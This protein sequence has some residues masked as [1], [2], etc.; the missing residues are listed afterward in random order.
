MVPG[1]NHHGTSFTCTI[2]E[3]DKEYDELSQIIQNYCQPSDYLPG[4]GEDTEIYFFQQKHGE[5]RWTFKTAK[6]Y[7]DEGGTR[8]RS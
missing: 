6:E 8:P 4:R 1:G 5:R 7:T 3:K 2:F